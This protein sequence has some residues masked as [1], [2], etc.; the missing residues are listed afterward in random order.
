M[1]QVYNLCALLLHD[2]P[3]DIYGSIMAVKKTCGGDNADGRNG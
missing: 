2:T 1:P 3:H